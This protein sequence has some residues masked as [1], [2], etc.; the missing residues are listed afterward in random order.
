MLAKALTKAICGD[1]SS[2]YAFHVNCWERHSL[3][4]VVQVI[5]DQLK[6]LGADAQDTNVKLDRIRHAIK[7]KPVVV[8]LDDVDRV[9]PSERGRIVYALLQ[10]PRTGLVC[11]SNHDKTLRSLDDRTR[12]RL[13]PLMIAFPRYRPGDIEAIL[14]DR[15]RDALSPGT[16]EDRALKRLASSA[17][18]DARAAIQGL[19]QGTVAAENSG[20]HQLQASAARK[21]SFK[22][23]TKESEAPANQ[24]A[25]HERLIYELATRHAPVQTTDLRHVYHT[26]CKKQRIAPV[27]PRTFSKYVKHLG[28]CGLLD[29]DNR[30]A[31]ARGRLIR[32]DAEASDG[33]RHSGLLNASD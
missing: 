3:Y 8:I 2:G 17:G 22:S 26:H 27:A 7:E 5:A 14:D 9:A 24:L 19:R 29:V 30:V 28:D 25:Y 6:V 18:G 31:S 13:S 10:L 4:Q 33:L 16:W 12:S 1:S 21:S 32:A 23:G 11:I 15:A 20:K